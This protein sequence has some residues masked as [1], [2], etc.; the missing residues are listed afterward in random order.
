MTSSTPPFH[1]SSLPSSSLQ[2]PSSSVP[3]FHSLGNG[4]VE[5]DQSMRNTQCNTAGTSS[6][7]ALASKVLER[8]KGWNKSGTAASNSVPHSDQP[9]PLRGTIAEVSCKAEADNLLYI[10][11]ERIAIAQYDGQQ[12]PLQAE[13]IAYLDAFV[14]VLANLPQEDPAYKENWL[15]DRIRAA[16]EWLQDQNLFQPK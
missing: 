14:S 1:S 2:S 8:N 16:K 5:Q 11:E 15:E 7:K 12:T 13:R 4:T 9:G 10:F 6:L 3:L